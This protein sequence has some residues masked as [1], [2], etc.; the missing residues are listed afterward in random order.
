MASAA[1]A[2]TRPS[3]EA[4][5]DV[6]IFGFGGSACGSRGFPGFFSGGRMSKE[7]SSTLGERWVPD[8]FS[9]GFIF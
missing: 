2:M 3:V 1:T 5:D 8:S 7:T 9:G 6:V 4:K